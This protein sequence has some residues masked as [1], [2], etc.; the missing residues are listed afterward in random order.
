[1]IDLARRPGLPNADV[2]LS[3][4]QWQRVEL[5]LSLFDLQRPIE[6]IT[7]SGNLSGTFYLDDLQLMP[8]IA[9]DGTGYR[10]YIW[11]TLS[12]LI[13]ETEADLSDLRISE[14]HYNPVDSDEYA[15]KDLEF[16]ELYNA[17]RQPLELSYAIFIEG[18]DFTFP[19]DTRLLPGRFMVLA[20]NRRAFASRYAVPPSGEF[21]GQL[22]NGGERLALSRASGETILRLK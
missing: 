16:I 12:H 15:G 4:S 7:F 10:P 6:K 11:S 8:I 5:P 19:G 1:M 18:I 21:S 20:A 3:R 9:D 2:D 14:I 17:G 13:L 22:N